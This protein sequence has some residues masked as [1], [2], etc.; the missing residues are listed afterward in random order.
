MSDAQ[1]FAEAARLAAA[2]TPF[3]VATVV[4]CEGS[5]PRKAGAKMLVRGDGSTL[6]TVGGGKVETD[7]VSDALAALTDG[8]PRL[9]VLALTEEHGY[10]CGGRMQIFIEPF[11]S[12][13]ELFIFGAGHVGRALAIAAKFA[14]FRVSVADERGA[15]SFPG[16]DGPADEVMVGT[17]GTLLPQLDVR[18]EAYIVIATSSHE[19]DFAAARAALATPAAY[20]GVIGSRRKRASLLQ[21]LQDEGWPEEALARLRIPVGLAIA[22]ETPEEIAISIVGQ[23]IEDRRKGA[24]EHR[25][26]PRCRGAF[27][28]VGDA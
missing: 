23:L 4:A 28:A 26:D 21:L 15:P 6:G 2:N 17:A 19:G 12:V 24:G 3:A 1:I 16:P 7:V 13:T 8:Q 25:G 9:Y 27:V 11:A 5:T 20:V 10:F 18:P 14:G 22:A